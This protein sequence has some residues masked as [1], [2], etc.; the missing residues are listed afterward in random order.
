M[1]HIRGTGEIGKEHLLYVVCPHAAVHGHGKNMHHFFS[2]QAEERRVQNALTT[3][4]A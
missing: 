3:L 4:F 1:H 2:M